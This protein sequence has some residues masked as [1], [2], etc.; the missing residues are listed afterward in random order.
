MSESQEEIIHLFFDYLSK[1]N[2]DE[3]KEYMVDLQ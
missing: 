1:F 2:H 3:A